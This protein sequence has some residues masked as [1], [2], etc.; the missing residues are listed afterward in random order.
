METVGLQQKLLFQ[1]RTL[2]IGRQG[3]DENL[4]ADFFPKQLLPCRHIIAGLEIG[5]QGGEQAPANRGIQRRLCAPR[6]H[7]NRG[8]AIRVVI[9]LAFNLK[10]FQ[11]LQQDVETT[12][13]QL[14]HA[15]QSTDTAH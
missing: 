3:I 10:P 15:G 1:G 11:P 2:Q 9:P 6:S 13:G 8:L 5:L 4:I 12:I 7:S 14:L